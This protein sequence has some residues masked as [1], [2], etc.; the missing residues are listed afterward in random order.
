M[1]KAVEEVKF[2][3]S[4]Y[5][6]KPNI[7]VIPPQLALYMALGP[8]EKTLYAT[9]GPK[10]DAQF[11]SGVEGFIARAFRGLAVVTADPFEIADDSEAVQMLTRTTQVGEHYFMSSPE[12]GTPLWHGD[13]A[14]V[15]FCDIVIY[16]TMVAAYFEQ[17]SCRSA[18]LQG[19]WANRSKAHV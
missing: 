10:A 14:T 13:E 3:M 12:K 1:D 9:G 19:P 5:G 18:D 4:R 11:E 15:G 6:V 17:R 2:R 7:M 16:S 8:E